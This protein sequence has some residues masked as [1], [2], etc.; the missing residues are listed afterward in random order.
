MYSFSGTSPDAAYTLRAVPH[1]V[2]DAES[3]NQISSLTFVA[4]DGRDRHMW[5]V[6]NQGRF[7]VDFSL[8]VDAGT[9]Y[10]LFQDLRNGKQVMFPGTF[11]L[12]V[13][14]LHLGG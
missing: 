2:F 14:K 4:S 10:R 11:K 9:A 12:E 1:L 8:L 13:L 6:V 7:V 5:A 3:G